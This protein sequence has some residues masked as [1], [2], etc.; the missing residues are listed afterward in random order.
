MPTRSRWEVITE[1]PLNIAAVIFLIAYAIPVANPDAPEW[2]LLTCEVVV[3]VTWGLFAVD[4][5]T[6]F[7]LAHDKWRFFR[8]NLVDLA[9]VV[10]PMLRPLRL[11]R[12]L[13]LLSILNR[14][15][16]QRLHGRVVTYTVGAVSLL[17]VIGALAVTDAERG[18]P[19]ANIENLGD[20]FWWAAVTIATV[21]YGDRFPVSPI[22]RGVAVALM[23]GGIALLGVV[24]A[25]IASW[26]V[27]RVADVT[28]Q[29]EI[30]TREQVDVLASELAEIKNQLAT[31]VARTQFEGELTATG[32]PVSTG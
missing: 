11:V 19:G 13:S 5:V 4:Y 31:L 6:R 10:L 29:Q 2:L 22:G 23:I 28:E 32:D 25:T 14:T 18:V 21:G 12:L 7:V 8:S 30:A 15:A 3:W 9:A 20:G 1:W 26:L 16:T 24:T 27:Q 17:V